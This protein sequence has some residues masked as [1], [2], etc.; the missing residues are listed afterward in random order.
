MNRINDRY[1]EDSYDCSVEQDNKRR[2]GFPETS[3][4]SIMGYRFNLTRVTIRVDNSHDN[5]MKKLRVEY[6]TLFLSI[7]DSNLSATRNY[8]NKVISLY[9]NERKLDGSMND[10]YGTRKLHTENLQPHF[11]KNIICRQNLQIIDF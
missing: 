7:M 4:I 3:Y 5:Y 9:G 8:L 6:A 10:N 2:L 11:N 1:A